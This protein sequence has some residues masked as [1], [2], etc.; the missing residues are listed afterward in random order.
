MA[1][2]DDRRWT[3]RDG[4]KVATGYK[5]EKPWRARWR[6]Y[7]GGPQK[8]QQFAKK[9]QAERWLDKVRGDLARG[10][11][12]DPTAGRVTFGQWW[13]QYAA[14]T[15]KRAT[16]AA[17]D[18][19]VA[20]R[21]LLPAFS[22]MPLASITPTSVRGLVDKMAAKLA[23]ATV[24]TNYGVL[25]AAMSAA[26]ESDL[27]GRSPCRGVKLPADDRDD[28]RF[29]TADELHRL[30]DSMP[31]EYRAL[32]Y[33]AGVLGLRFSEVAGLRVGR[34]DFPRGILTVTETVAEVEGRL[35]VAD[36]KTKASRRALTMPEAV[37]H[38]L[39]AHLARRGRPGPNEYVF[40]A[41]E[42]GPL[43]AG[44]FRSRVWAP[45][46]EAARLDDLTPHGLR[47]TAAGLM[48]ALGAH[49]RVIQKRM[50]HASIRTTFDVY[51]SV[52][53]SVDDAVTSGL[54]DLLSGASLATCAE[55]GA[56][57]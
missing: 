41:P 21:W 17:R 43:R 49:P 35:I 40:I 36:V 28:P 7:P 29:L 18:R 19:A 39:V 23:P 52:L 14:Q 33:V 10:T 55:Q 20:N 9:A 24:R 31:D 12:T 56:T 6:E 27:I 47:H 11:Y 37:T 32:V 2:I 25:R 4:E 22:G 3:K 34:V 30:A 53:P 38:E 5:G 15:P 26:V 8:T 44:A 46:V 51:G 16:T 50:G 42:G 57:K 48:I 54:D 45:A 13:E 1:S